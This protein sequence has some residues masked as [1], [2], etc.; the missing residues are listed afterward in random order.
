MTESNGKPPATGWYW[1]E[2]GTIDLIAK[3]GRLAFCI[4]AVIARFAGRDRVAEISPEKIGEYLGVSGRSI[5]AE[6]AKLASLEIIEIDTGRGRG[7]VN[8]YTLKGGSTVPPLEQQRRKSTSTKGRKGG[9]T[10]HERRK[11]TSTLR[12]L[13]LFL[14]K[15]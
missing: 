10:A 14:V 6:T 13:L 1:L 5:R 3:I 4:L 15:T 11:L 2:N 7:N 8:R 9:S 12:R